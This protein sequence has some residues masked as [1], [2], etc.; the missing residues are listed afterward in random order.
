MPTPVIHTKPGEHIVAMFSTHHL[1]QYLPATY[2]SLLAY[3]PDVHVYLFIEHDKLPYK[4]PANVTCVNITGQ[5]LFSETGPNYHSRYTYMILLKAA[6]TKIFPDAH[7]LVILDVDTITCDSISALWDYDLTY[8]HFASV[9]E[10]NGSKIRGIPYPNF[11]LVLLNLDK[12]RASGKDDEIIHLLNTRKYDF[13]E[14]DAFAQVCGNRFD[15]LPADYN[16]TQYGFNVTGET[17]HTIILHFAGFSA[18]VWSQFDI[19]RYWLTHTTPPPRYVVYASD[20][21]VQN[22][23]IASAKSL[24]AH[25]KVDKIFLL[26]DNDDIGK[27]L[28][29]IFQCINVSSQ[30]IFPVPGP[31]IMPFYGYMTTLRAGLTRILPQDIDTVLWLDPDTVVTDDISDLWNIDITNHYFAAV[32]E[33]R[34]HDHT[35]KPYF[36]AGVMLMNLRKFREDGMDQKVIDSINTTPYKHLEQDA[37]NYLCSLHIRRLPSF[38]SDS[39]V[40]EPCERPRIKH[41]LAQAKRD[42]APA[43]AP[44]ERMSWEE[45]LDNYTGK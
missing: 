22:M 7:R 21:R 19:T 27:T 29:Q 26:V 2:N 30:S 12:L 33:V 25:T 5:D 39:Y 36:N 20:H 41:F 15:P 32:E 11:G 9:I 14:Q 42:F 35:L 31:N 3:N 4:T 1:Y 44:Y 40:S 28:P 6:M 37:L 34:N 18:D 24:I 17:T 8:A 43:A 23:M 13:P 38:Y 10:P 45:L 16:N